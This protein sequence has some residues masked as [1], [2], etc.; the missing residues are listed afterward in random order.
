M[1]CNLTGSEHTA[2]ML[3]G[4]ALGLQ[5]STARSLVPQP[6]QGL[7]LVCRVPIRPVSCQAAASDDPFEVCAV[8]HFWVEMWH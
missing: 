4:R 3:A 7:P 6:R 2:N 5:G 1:R 8:Q